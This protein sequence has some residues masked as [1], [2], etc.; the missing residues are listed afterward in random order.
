MTCSVEDLHFD[1]L[2]TIYLKP[3][4]LNVCADSLRFDW[5]QLEVF[6]QKLIDETCFSYVA[7]ANDTDLDDW[8]TLFFIYSLENFVPDIGWF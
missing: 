1:H 3:H 7:V 5:S 4:I 6:A 2:T 8:N